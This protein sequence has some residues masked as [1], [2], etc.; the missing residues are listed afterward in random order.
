[1]D[2]KEITNEIHEIIQTYC[3]GCFLRES[4]RK[5]HSKNYAQRFCIEKCTV[6]ERLKKCGDLLSNKK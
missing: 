4:F 6:G 1:M 5:D 3:D 2:K